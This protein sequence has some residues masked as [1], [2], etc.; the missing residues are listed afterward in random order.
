MARPRCAAAHPRA[1]PIT[2]S[3]RDVEVWRF[4]VGEALSVTRKVG[5]K[6]MPEVMLTTLVC[7]ALALAISPATLVA[8]T[9]GCEPVSQR[10]GREFGCFITAREELG[11][12]PKDSA[13]NWH[14]D[15]YP[16]RAAAQAARGPGG[17]VVESLGRTWLF[18][19][20]GASS[21]LD[22]SP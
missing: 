18:T 17:P 15:A 19:I 5:G 8:Q 3:R 16:A 22:R 7:S 10:A 2:T 20:A 14:L 1:A 9:E 13:L 4:L 12:V 11:C 6:S 21:Q